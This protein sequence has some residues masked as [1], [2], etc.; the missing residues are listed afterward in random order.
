MTTR[1]IAFLLACVL[2]LHATAAEPTAK[3]LAVSLE[4]S[5][6]EGLSLR[7]LARAV[8]ELECEQHEVH[9]R[10]SKV[11]ESIEV[12]GFRP[13]LPTEDSETEPY[14]VVLQRAKPAWNELAPHQ[15]RLIEKLCTVRQALVISKH[16][17]KLEG[18][19][20][21]QEKLRIIE[22]CLEYMDEHAIAAKLVEVERLFRLEPVCLH[23]AM[24]ANNTMPFRR[25][26]KLSLLIRN[27]R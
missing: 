16:R 7:R 9:L 5:T 14:S 15:A 18:S 25:L 11:I 27:Q 26:N 17:L 12:V 23:S 21:S 24:N 22:R 6:G 19:Q 10:L 1:H 20:A 3:D 13:L 4:S 8:R 2:P